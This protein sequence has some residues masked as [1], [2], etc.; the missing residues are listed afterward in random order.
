MG[1][2][3]RLFKRYAGPLG[4]IGSAES[5]I[6]SHENLAAILD[7]TVDSIITIDKNGAILAFN[8]A[9]EQVFGFKKEEVLGKN[10]NI[11]MP[12]P[13][14]SQHDAYMQNY[15]STRQKKIIGIG[16]E[17]VA[18][19]KD[20]SIFPIRL[21][22]SEFFTGK[23]HLFTGILRD[24]TAENEAEEVLTAR[25]RLEGELAAKNEYIAILSHELKNPLAAIYGSLSLLNKQEDFTEKTHDLVNIAFRNS[26]RLQRIINDVLD[27]TKF[28]YGKVQLDITPISILELIQEAI[29]LS[30][31]F[32][33]LLEVTFEYTRPSV[34]MTILSDYNRLIEVMMNLLSNAVKFSP[35]KSKVI[36]TATALE[37]TVRV[38]VQDFGKG[39]PAD[40]QKNI[41]SQFSQSPTNGARAV[42]GTGLGLHI[43]K[44][45]IEQ[46]NGKISFISKENEGTTFFFELPIYKGEI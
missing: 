15:L 19:R 13:F 42:G 16:R 1:K 14:R 38:A 43:C 9:A 31:P 11:L 8:K 39:I 30:K 7:T 40:F 26:E 20:G 5:G 18:K 41:F 17:A 23:E 34:D 37:D 3:K 27:I 24:L 4:Q 36:I 45:I 46:L 44:L 12:E 33:A 6:L 32:G 25:V 10:V 21:A 22:V 35:Q 29:E 2:V 28:Q